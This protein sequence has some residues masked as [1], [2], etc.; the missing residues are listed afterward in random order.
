MFK[1]PSRRKSNRHAGLRR[2]DSNDGKTPPGSPI[3]SR[4]PRRVSSPLSLRPPVFV[5]RNTRGFGFSVKSIRVY[6]GQSSNYT[7]QH[8]IEVSLIDFIVLVYF[9]LIF[10]SLKKPKKFHLSY[11]FCSN[12]F[13]S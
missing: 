10:P 1:R 6:I 12:F 9:S 11:C 3:Q 8:L 2:R 5:T 7:M 4:D 13:Q